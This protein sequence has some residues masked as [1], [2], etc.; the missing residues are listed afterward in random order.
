MESF[1]K[2]AVDFQLFITSLD[3]SGPILFGMMVVLIMMLYRLNKSPSTKFFYDQIFLDDDGKKAST[4]K[5]SVIVALLL[6][7]WA[8]I[9]LTLKG[10]L[11][12]WYFI[13]YMSVWVLNRGFTKWLDVKAYIPQITAAAPNK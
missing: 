7:S 4:S 2:T 6:S 9:H 1:L 5:L 12:E 11:S 3:Y 10:D 8:F 13:G